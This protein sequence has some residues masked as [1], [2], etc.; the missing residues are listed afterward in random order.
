MSVF[1]PLLYVLEDSGR[2]ARWNFPLAVNTP[3]LDFAGIGTAVSVTYSFMAGVPAGYESPGDHPGFAV[4]DTGMQAGARQALAEW[5]AVA[6]LTFTEVSDAGDGGQIRFGQESMTGIGG[7]AY[8]PNFA[9]GFNPLTSIVTN[10]N[11]VPWMGDIYIS[12]D[13]NNDAVAEG[14][15]GYYVLVH[16]LGHAIGL[17]HPFEGTDPWRPRRTICVTPSWP[18]RSRQTSGSSPSP[19]MPAATPGASQ[20]LSQHAD[21]LR[22]RRGTVSLRRQHRDQRR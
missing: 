2:S 6:N 19:A 5:A 12:T 21:A 9:Y 4:F 11:P 10:Y 17:Q 20:S 16:E 3:L 8:P 22:H 18:I 15:Y 14:A 7:Y 1:D 13:S